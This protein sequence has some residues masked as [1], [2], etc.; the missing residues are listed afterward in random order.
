[1]VAAW[2]PLAVRGG[3]RRVL[4]ALALLGAGLGSI[5]SLLWQVR[6]V[7]DSL[8]P[9]GRLMPALGWGCSRLLL[10]EPATRA[11]RAVLQLSG[12]VAIAAPSPTEQGVPAR[13][14]GAGEVI[15]ILERWILVVLLVGQQYAA[16]GFVVTAK[17]LAR[18]KQMEERAFAE[19][20]LVGTLTSMLIAMAVAAMLRDLL[21]A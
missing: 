11:C 16:L 7:G 9:L 12:R 19:Y 20:F 8:L 4:L 10:M 15:G 13:A 14:L 2:E 1:M 3:L 18:H 5:G 6:P 21:R 17:T